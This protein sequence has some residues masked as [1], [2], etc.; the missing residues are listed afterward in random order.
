MT[1]KDS[2]P[3]FGRLSY[4][5][6]TDAICLIHNLLMER[7]TERNSH[8]KIYIGKSNSE[9]PSQAFVYLKSVIC[10]FLY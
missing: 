7:N 2:L 1:K 6:T 3:E 10:F 8:M 4:P 9:F 5:Y